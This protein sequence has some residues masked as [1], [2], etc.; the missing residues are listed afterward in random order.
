MVNY[1]TGKAASLIDVHPRT[2]RRWMDRGL[3][4]YV[5]LP[6]GERRIPADELDAI[7]QRRG[8]KSA[9]NPPEIAA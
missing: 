3:L 2:L 7:L 5:Q 8:G 4:G 1:R 6:S 9:P